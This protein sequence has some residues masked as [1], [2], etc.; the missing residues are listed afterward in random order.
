MAKSMKYSAPKF[1]PLAHFL[2][3]T[4]T[5][6]TVEADQM[7]MAIG[8]EYVSA[9]TF[10]GLFG[11]SA[12]HH[13]RQAEKAQNHLQRFAPKDEISHALQGVGPVEQLSFDSRPLGEQRALEHGRERLHERR[14]LRQARERLLEL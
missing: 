4:C 5:L 14:V 9:K 10:K 12:M 3:P 1:F 2:S 6:E 8:V 11:D 13:A 7:A